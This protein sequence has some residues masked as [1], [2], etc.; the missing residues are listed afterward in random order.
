V[1][2][3]C[4]F[5]IDSVVLQLDGS[6]G[7]PAEMVKL[8]SN[9]SKLYTSLVAYAVVNAVFL[10]GSIFF[11]KQHFVRT[12]FGVL[13][14]DVVV[15]A[16]NFKVMQALVGHELSTVMPFSGMSLH[17]GREWFSINLPEAQSVWLW[18]VPLGVMLLAWAAAYQRV[19]EKQI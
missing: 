3:G 15:M 19:T 5:L 18:L 7:Q 4:F 11:Q 2:I 8:F 10:W 14:V 13:L 12:A 1:Y 17:E 6:A 9:E 16:L